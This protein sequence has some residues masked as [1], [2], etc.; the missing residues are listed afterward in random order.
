[1]GSTKSDDQL[2]EKGKVTEKVGRENGG[3]RASRTA[4]A[5]QLPTGVPAK[6]GATLAVMTR[7]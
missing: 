5:I 1:M 7:P 3:R 2:R 6:G 4:R